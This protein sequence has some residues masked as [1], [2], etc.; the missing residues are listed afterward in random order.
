MDVLGIRRLRT[1]AQTIFES[2]PQILLQA[3]I[4]QYG[5]S[6]LG[7]D[8]ETLILSLAAASL[9]FMLE[10]MMLYYESTAC[11]TSVVYY[12]VVCLN[13]RLNWVPF[14]EKMTRA[15]TTADKNEFDY[16]D[17]HYKLCG[18]KFHMQYEFYNETM[19]LLA[20]S[21]V[22]IPTPDKPELQ[23]KMRMGDVCKAVDLHHFILL[24]TACEGKIVIC[25]D[26]IDWH[27]IIRHT[28]K[29]G[30]G[31]IP[32]SETGEPL[33]ITVI[34]LGMA[35]C[36]DALLD[37]GASTSVTNAAGLSPLHLATDLQRDKCVE[38][39]IRHGTYV[40]DILKNTNIINK[41]FASTRR[42]E[43]L[44]ATMKH[45]F[46][47]FADQ[48]RYGIMDTAMKCFDE[49]KEAE[50]QEIINLLGGVST[51][52]GVES[53]EGR[54]SRLGSTKAIQSFL[55]Y[56][57]MA[58]QDIW[59]T[60]GTAEAFS[61]DRAIIERFRRLRL[62]LPGPRPLGVVK[63]NISLGSKDHPYQLQLFD[64]QKS[65]FEMVYDIISLKSLPA[66][67]KAAHLRDY[68]KLANYLCL[69]EVAFP[70][71]YKVTGEFRET[72]VITMQSTETYKAGPSEAE[73]EPYKF[74]IDLNGEKYKHM[75]TAKFPENAVAVKTVEFIGNVADQGWG[76][77][78]VR[79]SLYVRDKTD[80]YHMFLVHVDRDKVRDNRYNVKFDDKILE[81]QKQHCTGIDVDTIL[82]CPQWPGFSSTCSNFELKI[83]CYTD[84][85]KKDYE[86]MNLLSSP[87]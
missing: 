83:T 67:F 75:T 55:S 80:S 62:E 35:K 41:I 12:S 33:V 5:A 52:I 30:M 68:D 40:N 24:Y 77:K 21:T 20:D 13:G 3:R 45:S 73:T 31:E 9:H 17:I 78:G 28:F 42:T 79:F 54:V 44:V 19:K 46:I 2:I 43:L 86:N 29:A 51:E 36:L 63:D 65:T 10:I 11:K 85:Y 39:L 47:G 6:Y 14:M 61:F 34:R 58:P 57:N 84:Q 15:R 82:V 69:D 4:L 23:F 72:V 50:G 48:R 38:V 26:D 76:G 8:S 1:I 74:Q 16:S 87:L 37:E 49:D 66:D 27:H 32:L 81:I 22:F 53:I 7:V 18:A 71:Y 25:E 60:F 64:I 70:I 56:K 59:M